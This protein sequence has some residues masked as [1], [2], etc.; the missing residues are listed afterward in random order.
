MP[1]S[2]SLAEFD[3]QCRRLC[4]V[5]KTVFLVEEAER[6]LGQGKML[7]PYAFDL[8]NRGR[9]WGIGVIAVTRRIQR[10]SKDFFDLCSHA[11]LFQTGLKSRDYIADMIGW[12]ATR[13]IIGLERFN[14]VH[15]NVEDETWSVN[16]LEPQLVSRVTSEDLTTKP[17][18]GVREKAED[19]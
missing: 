15:Y 18:K 8:I 10:L 13:A 3:A 14:F 12:E 19:D 11:Y 9:N 17:R 2:D 5:S 1:K 7:G 4:V 6:Y 16:V